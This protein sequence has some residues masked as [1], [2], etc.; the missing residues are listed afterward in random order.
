M[1]LLNH[2]MLYYV[3]SP[4][5]FIFFQLHPHPHPHYYTRLRVF[6]SWPNSTYLI[7]FNN[8]FSSLFIPCL[9]RLKSVTPSSIPPI[10]LDITEVSNFK[11]RERER[12]RERRQRSKQCLISHHCL[13]GTL[14]HACR[15]RHAARTDPKII[16]RLAST[17]ISI[18]RF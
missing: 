8:F 14:A 6:D 10:T 16:I 9:K 12:E 3:S 15:A 2:G 1:S 17:R 13:N 7:P 5:L 18:P 11:Q 4:L